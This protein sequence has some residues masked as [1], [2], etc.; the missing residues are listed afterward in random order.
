[1]LIESV[2]IEEGRPMAAF[3]LSGVELRLSIGRARI[4]PM[5]FHARGAR[6][7]QQVL[8]AA[9]TGALIALLAACGNKPS[10]QSAAAQP[11]QPVHAAVDTRLPQ[12]CVDA[13]KLQ[14]ECTGRKA[15]RWESAGQADSAKELRE[16]LKTNTESTIETWKGVNQE[17]LTKTCEQML[18][19]LPQSTVC[20]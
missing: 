2:L 1:V 13:L 14:A 12:A 8:R 7:R 20:Q 16:V 3:L 10:P 9:T 17:G 18:A 4:F 6:T 11:Q 5:N 15:K 19:M